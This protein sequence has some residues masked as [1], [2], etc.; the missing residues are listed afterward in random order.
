MPRGARWG[1]NLDGP[2]GSSAPG[3]SLG[4]KPGWAGGVICP[5]ALVG[6]EA[7]VGGVKCPGALENLLVEAEQPGRAGGVKCR[8]AQVL[9]RAVVGRVVSWG[10]RLCRSGVT[11]PG[12]F[13][14]SRTVDRRGQ[15]PWGAL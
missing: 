9:S 5:G 2:A 13:A 12:A 4:P 11:C 14:G 1:R 7:W 3:R 6:A 15:L 10:D 8:G